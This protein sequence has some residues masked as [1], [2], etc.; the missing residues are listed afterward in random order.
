MQAVDGLAIHHVEHDADDGRTLPAMQA[1]NMVISGGAA[2]E[3]HPLARM[4]RRQSPDALVEACGLLEA[5]GHELDAA[6]AADKTIRHFPR[7][8]KDRSPAECPHPA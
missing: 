4:D 3:P 8:A 6:H 2:I 1:E 5:R 7:P